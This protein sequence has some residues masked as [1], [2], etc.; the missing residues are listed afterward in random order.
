MTVELLV[1]E[2]GFGTKDQIILQDVSC[3]IEKGKIY[4]IIGPNGSGKSTLLKTLSHHLKPTNGTVYINGKKVQS[5]SV[6]ELAKQ[7]AIVSQSPEAPADLTVKELV[8]FGRFPYRKMFQTTGY[9]DKEIIADAI[10]KTQ[11]S[12]L[13]NRKVVSLSGGE[14]QRAWIAM[15]LAQQPDILI[16]DEPTTYLDIFHQYEIMELITNLNKSQKMT[17]VMVVH[18]LNHAGQYSDYIFVLH[19]HTIAAEGVPTEVLEPELLRRIFRI[20][21]ERQIQADNRLLIIPK[22]LAVPQVNGK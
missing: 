21:C 13:A 11:L 14:R 9:D 7:I 6:K 2:V 16:L 3:K 1:D 10:E 12:H 15:A 20:E 5:I 18:D 4:S 22:G 17:V 8:S 19:D